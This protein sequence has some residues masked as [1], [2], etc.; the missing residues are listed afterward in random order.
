M[1]D[2]DYLNDLWN[3]VNAEDPDR[4]PAEEVKKILEE[5]RDLRHV[6]LQNVKV[7]ESLA[8]DTVTVERC[9]FVVEEPA[10]VPMKAS[11]SEAQEA[12]ARLYN[13]FNKYSSVG[14]DEN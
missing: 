4:I 6:T 11:V 8:L 5:L 7:R 9:L 2:S 1:L 3:Q 13:F 10:S 14:K 12:I